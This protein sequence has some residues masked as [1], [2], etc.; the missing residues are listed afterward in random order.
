MRKLAAWLL[1]TASVA[2]AGG[3]PAPD[4][5]VY[6]VR[7]AEKTSETEDPGLTPDGAERADRLAAW[8]HGHGIAR[9]YS[10]DFRRTR[11]TAA[12]IAAAAGAPLDLY[13]PRELETVATQLSARG[14]TALVVGHSNTTPQ[15]AAL[16]CACVAPPMDE[17]VY[18][19]IYVVRVSGGRASLSVRSQPTP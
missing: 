7:H 19:R 13:D 11:D 12:P 3:D 5:T 9:V 15:L 8:T 18:D 14:E 2:W 17:S 6:L 10:S 4:Y 16:L 1:L